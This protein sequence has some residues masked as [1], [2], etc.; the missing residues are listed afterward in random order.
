MRFNPGYMCGDWLRRR[1]AGAV[2][3][4]ALMLA[5]LF[6]AASMAPPGGEA[7]RLLADTRV[8][9]TLAGMRPAGQP[10][11][12]DHVFC[13]FCLPLAHAA[14]TAAATPAVA[15]PPAVGGE[16]L[17][18]PAVRALRVEARRLLPPV[19]A[20]PFRPEYKATIA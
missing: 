5:D 16:T 2:L 15:P 8:V 20:P 17:A 7:A 11:G 9:C 18:I 14:G 12:T 19:R 13:V 10:A 4:L 6:G 1:Q 3:G